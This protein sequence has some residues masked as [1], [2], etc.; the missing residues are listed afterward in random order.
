SRAHALEHALAVRLVHEVLELRELAEER[1]PEL[2]NRA[3]ALLA[4]DDVSDALARRIAVVDFLAVD[5][6]DQVRVLLDGSRL[7]QI[8]HHGLLVVAL[9]DA[10][11][12]LR[13]RDHWSVELCREGLERAQYFGELRRPVLDVARYRHQLEIIDHDQPEPVLAL[14]AARARSNL[15]RRQRAAVVDQDRR[16]R[17]HRHRRVHARPV[18]LGELAVAEPSLAH[19]PDGAQ[20]PEAQLLRGHFHAE[21]ANWNLRTNRGVLGDIDSQTGFAHGR[22]PRDD[23]ELAALEAGRHLVHLG[24]AGGHARDLALRVAQ[25]V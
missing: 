22:P 4:D 6:H 10:A 21:D 1:E 2:P 13:P 14:Q 25:S 17:H 3:V 24:K 12:E 5:E 16:A 7:A 11:V 20:H 9:L 23:D 18:V 8:R 15:G 19:A